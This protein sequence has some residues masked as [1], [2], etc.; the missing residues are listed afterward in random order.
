M[1]E[2]MQTWKDGNE[3][4][5][6][7]QNGRTNALGIDGRTTLTDIPEGTISRDFGAAK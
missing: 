7:P 6:G 4:K 3:P 1:Q 5:V 2:L